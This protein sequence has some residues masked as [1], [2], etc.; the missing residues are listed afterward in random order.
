[1]SHHNYLSQALIYI[2]KRIRTRPSAHHEEISGEIPILHIIYRIGIKSQCMT[3]FFFF[4]A[5]Q[6]MTHLMS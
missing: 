4:L 5:K 1:M 2:I 3:H 6:C